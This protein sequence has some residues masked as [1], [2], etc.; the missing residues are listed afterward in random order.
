MSNEQRFAMAAMTTDTIQKEV[1]DQGICVVTLNRPE[2]MNAM[3]G[4][5]VDFLWHT[6]YELH[7]DPSVRVVILTGAGEKAFCAGADLTE[8]RGM[9]EAA[10]RKR[11]DDYG[12]C[13]RA[14]EQVS[15]PVICAINGYAFGGGLELALACDVRVMAEETK[16]GLTELKLGIIPGAGGTQRLPRLIGL[17]RAKELIFTAARVQAPRALALGLV[18]DTAPRA[19]LMARAKAMAGQMLGCGPIAL[20]QAKLAINAGMQTDLETG[21]KLESRAY[22]TTLPTH[23]RIEGLNAFKEGRPPTFTGT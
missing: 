15:K 20:A 11:I 16:V 10:V 8:R 5:L 14:V 3:N 12:H 21:L 18:N 13:F 23:D 7:H 9:S 2:V 17:G 6:F 1:D 4:E 22:A 19:A